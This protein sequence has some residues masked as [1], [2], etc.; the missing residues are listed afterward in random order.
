MVPSEWLSIELPWAFCSSQLR[1]NSVLTLLHNTM[2]VLSHWSISMGNDSHSFLLKA[3]RSFLG[4]PKQK[5]YSGSGNTSTRAGV[6]EMRKEDSAVSPACACRRKGALTG[7]LA[8]NLRGFIILSEGV[9]CSLKPI[10]S[11]VLEFWTSN[12]HPKN[13]MRNSVKR[14]GPHGTITDACLKWHDK[15]MWLASMITRA[16]VFLQA[17]LSRNAFSVHTGATP[18]DP[19]SLRSTGAFQLLLTMT[20]SHRAS[21]FMGL[22]ICVMDGACDIKHL[23]RH[24]K[25]CPRSQ[26]SRCLVSKRSQSNGYHLLF[27]LTSH[28]RSCYS[29]KATQSWDGNPFHSFVS[30][31]IEGDLDSS[32]TNWESHWIMSAPIGLVLLTST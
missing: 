32:I 31:K 10:D 26:Q 1:D 22:F 12:P 23:D 30:V 17:F 9:Y 6:V 3:P 14:D 5:R 29:W 19:N 21:P 25:S 4:F 15:E 24:F 18:K 13:S 16:W 27:S 20:N 28:P 8:A 7:N 11:R 2:Q